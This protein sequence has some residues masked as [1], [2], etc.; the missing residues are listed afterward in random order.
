ML[1][2]PCAFH[3]QCRCHRC[4]VSFK[5]RFFGSACCCCSC[6]CS[7]SSAAPGCEDVTCRH[8]TSHRRAR[9]SCRRCCSH[10][11]SETSVLGLNDVILSS[12]IHNAI[13]RGHCFSSTLRCHIYCCSCILCCS[14]SD[15]RLLHSQLA[16]APSSS[17]IG[18]A[19]C[20]L[21]RLCMR[22]CSLLVPLCQLHI[23]VNNSSLPQGLLKCYL[24]LLCCFGCCSCCHGQASTGV[25]HS[26]C[27]CSH[28]VQPHD[29][30]K[31]ACFKGAM[32]LG[33]CHQDWLVDVGSQ[34]VHP[35]QH[36]VH[37]SQPSSAAFCTA[38]TAVWCRHYGDQHGFVLLTIHS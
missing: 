34:Q 29:T 18:I 5:C 20:N 23:A 24:C 38:A 16:A 27:S 12:C 25:F 1:G 21:R 9:G 33:L 2:A 8:D 19:R 36:H 35:Q 6:C 28:A 31:E 14:F 22:F 15:A 26:S 17:C 10:K 7:R 3:C 37:V 32:G 13:T 4:C 11:G 30:C